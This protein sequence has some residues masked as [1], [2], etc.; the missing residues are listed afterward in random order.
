MK[1]EFLIMKE[2]IIDFFI[3]IH[4]YVSTHLLARIAVAILIFFSFVFFRRLFSKLVL[5][6]IENWMEETKPYIQEKILDELEDPIK[7]V[8]IILGIY[9]AAEYL[10]PFP[11]KVE[12][13]TS[14][15]IYTLF[16]FTIF[17]AL[18]N[19]VGPFLILLNKVDQKHVIRSA[20][21]D[22]LVKTLKFIIVA[23]AMYAIIEGIWGLPI[24]PMIASLG[25]LS[26]AVALGAQDLFKNI[27][28]GITVIT[29]NRFN[30]GDI[31]SVKEKAE[32]VVEKIGFRSTLIRRFDQAP[33]YVPNADL[34]DSAVINYSTRKYR[35]IE[36]TIGLEYRTTG[37]Q[38]KYIRDEIE[39]YI[40]SDDRFAHPPD[41]SVQVRISEF[42]GSSINMM[43]YCFTN[44]NVWID[45]LDIKEDLALKV[46]DIVKKAKAS[47]AFPSQSLYIEKVDNRLKLNEKIKLPRRTKKKK[48]DDSFDIKKKTAGARGADGDD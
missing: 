38:L 32:G 48:I 45:W 42:A 13:I 17:W 47:F 6:R 16:T 46:K 15:F 4:N 41:A 8:P 10:K 26:V 24:M 22:W 12:L 9:S 3:S 7:F 36:W 21:M 5:K 20:M 33:V 28:A 37:E 31:I 23:I 39:T 14:K 11:L 19:I 2:E 34:S 30:I 44:T 40:L 25:L 18:F 35:R 1:L 43:I 27:I 29:E